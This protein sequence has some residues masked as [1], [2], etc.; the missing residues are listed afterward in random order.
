MVTPDEQAALARYETAL[1]PHRAAFAGRHALRLLGGAGQYPDIVHLFLIRFAAAGI[2]MT[3]PVEGWIRRA[4]ER[5]CALG[6]YELGNALVGHAAE[7]SRHHRLMAADLRVLCDRW[8]AIHRRQIDGVALARAGRTAA[9]RRYEALHEDIVAGDRPYAQ[10]AVEHEIE[11]LSVRYGAE[12]LAAGGQVGGDG[13]SFLRTHV[14]ADV[15]HG[16]FNRTQLAR[17]LALRPD[18]LPALAEAGAAALDAY[19]AFLDECLA[20]AL[21]SEPPADERVLDCALHPPPGTQP[22]PGWLADARALRTRVLHDGGRR[23][24]F[25]PRGGAFGDT[26][27]ADLACWHFVLSDD[28][29]PV[30]TIRVLP[31]TAPQV[32]ALSMAERTFGP[33]EL[34]A[35]LAREGLSREGCVE[36]SRLVLDPGYRGGATVRRLLAGAWAFAAESG[37]RA[38]LAAAG[39]RDRQ[40]R[41]LALFGARPVAGIAP[42][43]SERFDDDMRLMLFP[44]DPADPPDYPE[45]AIMQGLVAARFAHVGLRDAAA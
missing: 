26:D 31:A 11:A 42:R 13:L 22:L 40:D 6:H 3:R 24:A 1:A 15:R 21:R 41:M 33:A 38:I 39:T 36:A 8:N 10:I 20:A 4:G 18:A 7:E 2:A 35:A 37:A 45:I 32:R 16:A 34:D 43:H 27:P 19:G 12:L 17:F 30:G 23:P 14:A 9:V 44:V 5:C 29:L 25:A 28:G